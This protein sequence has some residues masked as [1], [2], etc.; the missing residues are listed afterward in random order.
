MTTLLSARSRP[1]ATRPMLATAFLMTLAFM[2]MGQTSEGQP[3][4]SQTVVH[5]NDPVDWRWAL[6]QG[7]LTIVTLVLGWSYKREL[8]RWAEEKAELQGVVSGLQLKVMEEKAA[9]QQARAD[10][11]IRYNRQLEMTLGRANDTERLISDSLS[12][13]TTALSRNTDSTHRLAHAV[14]GLDKRLERI[15]HQE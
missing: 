13:H 9:F 3:A 15:E 7:G 2:G 11:A 1:R 5:E 6:T 8:T 12:V 4:V 10:E 14:E